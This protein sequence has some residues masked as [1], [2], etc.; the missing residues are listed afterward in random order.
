MR[1]ALFIGG[2]GTISGEITRLLAQQYQDSWQ[3]FILNRGQRSFSLPNGVH[4]LSGDI[5]HEEQISR[6]LSDMY[7]DTVANFINFTVSDVERDLRLFRGKTDQYMFISSASAYQKPPADFY[8]DESVPLHNPFWQYSRDKAACEELLLREYRNSGF[9][10]TIVRPSH[11]YDDRKIPVSFHGKNGSWQTIDRILKGKEI[12]IPGDGNSL[13]TMTHSRDFARGFVGLMGNAHAVGQAVHITSDESLTWN[14]IYD[15]IG[16]ALG[17]QVKAVHITSDFLIAANPDLR[18][19]LLGDKSNTVVFN[20]AKLKRLV[21]G[22]SAQIRYDEG[23]RR[24]ISYYMSH[25]ELQ[26]P[27]EEFDQWCD[28]VLS[29]YHQAEERVKEKLSQTNRQL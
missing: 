14:Q 18:G 3:I 8:I 16:K 6:L 12:I 27:D 7:F 1:K 25:P 20:N 26:E 17:R 28:I 15:T 21:P 4:L 10:C 23:V 11:T 22:F 24:A 13:W 19:P 9:P 29:E 2:T 5:Y